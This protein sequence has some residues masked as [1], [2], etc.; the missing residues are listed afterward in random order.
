[1]WW[2]TALAAEARDAIVGESD[3]VWEVGTKMRAAILR[4]VLYFDIFKH[5]LTVAE[6]ERLIAPGRREAILDAAAAL[7]AE[8]LIEATGPYRHLP[9][10]GR[11][12]T[13]RQE[14]ARQAELAWPQARRAAAILGAL[15]F[16]Q[17]VMITG[18]LSKNSAIPDGDVDFLLLVEPGRVWSIKSLTQVARKAMPAPL[19]ELFCTNYLL[20]TSHL[21]IEE[22]NLFTAVE[23]STA[24]PMH[25]PKACAAFV[26]AN[27]WAGRFVPG[28]PWSLERARRA[29]RLPRPA[30]S[31]GVERLWRGAAATALESRSRSM[32]DRYWRRKYDWLTE[33]SRT[34]RFQRGAEVSTNHLHD[35][36]GYVLREASSR[37]AMAGLEEELRL[38]E[39][40]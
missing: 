35:F 11:H 27:D 13:R 7:R 19:R 22:R 5:P 14:R 33:E 1:M 2:T 25:G 17:G 15:P 39:A 30:L 4:M 10:A 28:L 31:R 24:V 23:L 9:G 37:F 29:R 36:Q 21:S 34:R 20:S 40:P 8:G 16:V 26:L 32:W 12:I 3:V 38:C 6:L 18:S